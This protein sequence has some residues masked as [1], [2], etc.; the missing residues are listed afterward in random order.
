MLPVLQSRSAIAEVRG[1]VGWY[2]RG[3][4]GR[5]EG[6]GVLPFFAD[7]RRVGRFAVDVAALRERRDEALFKLLVLFGLYQSRRDVDIM[8][9]QREMK[10]STVTALARLPTVK[11]HIAASRCEAM[12]APETFNAQCDV[13][14]DI[15]RGTASCHHRP[16]TPCHVKNASL[17]IG[18][19]GDMGKLPTSASL[20]LGASGFSR[21]M[22]DICRDVA[23]PAERAAEMVKRLQAI[24]R[25]GRKL[26]TMFVSALSVPE[27]SDVSP[28]VPDV[29]G[30]NLLVIDTNVMRVMDSIFPAGSR[31]YD[32][33]SQ[34]LRAVS[35]SIDLRELDR[36]LPKHSPRLVQQALY[37]FGSASNR[38]NARDACA[39][40]ICAGCPSVACP[41]VG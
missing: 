32:G 6:P 21:W 20:S 10:S 16:R 11:R 9:L 37:W 30:R 41:F 1:I 27:L 23:G 40:A 39:T 38:R 5:V 29:N 3:V 31:T 8:R 12:Q 24:H 4:Y 15:G 19:M 36:S 7:Q 34:T 26:A 25:I 35:R 13:Y 2:L 33:R 28:W 22:S 18:R 17:A 14:R